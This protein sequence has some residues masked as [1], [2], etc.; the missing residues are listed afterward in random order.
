MTAG[1]LE[2]AAGG[3]LGAPAR[4]AVDRW[5]SSR[6]GGLFP[7][8]TFAVNA[9]GAFVL[10]LLTALA[11]YQHAGDLVATLVG[12][13]FCGSYTT[14]STF[15]YQTLRLIEEGALRPAVANVGGSLLA[16]LLAAGAGLAIG[17]AA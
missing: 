7:W 15:S 9:T 16:G 12:A 8:G 11:Q 10:G 14:F 3:F 17:W 4:L 1:L 2:V 13:G 6:S 5:L